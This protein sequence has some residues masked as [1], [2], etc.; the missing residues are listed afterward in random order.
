MFARSGTNDL[1][2][3]PIVNHREKLET[4]PDDRVIRLQPLDRGFRDRSVELKIRFDL[5]QVANGCL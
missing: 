5:G 4:M 1:V 3:V 2:V